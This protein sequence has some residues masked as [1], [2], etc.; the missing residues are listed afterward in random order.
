MA[1]ERISEFKSMS[2]ETS[3]TEKQRETKEQKIKGTDY[4]KMRDK[5]KRSKISAIGI[6]EG[7]EREKERK[8]YSK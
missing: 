4:L 2:I 8:K 6:P 3:Q 5:Y 7:Q 1:E